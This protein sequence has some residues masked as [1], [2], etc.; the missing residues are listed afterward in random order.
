MGLYC[1][2]AVPSQAPGSFSVATLSSTSIKASWQL[3]PQNS[4]HGILTGFKLFYKYKDSAGSF[5]VLRI[6]DGAVITTDVTGL[7]KYTEYEF[8]VLAFTSVGDGPT[9][10][11]KVEITK[12]DG[13]KS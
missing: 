4:R 11:V 7:K 8:K 10:S 2:I 3:P 13:K 1:S 9:S 12:E 5:T 6:N